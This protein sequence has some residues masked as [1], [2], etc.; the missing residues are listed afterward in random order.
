M[1][2]NTVLY[3]QEKRPRVCQ[4]CNMC[5]SRPAGEVPAGSKFT[6]YCLLK[7]LE[8]SGRGIKAEDKQFKFRCKVNE[9]RKAYANYDGAFVISKEL[10]KKFGISETLLP[11]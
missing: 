7:G 4:E 2:A 3:M 1:G 6:H 10:V 8:L 9:Y 5:V 11:L